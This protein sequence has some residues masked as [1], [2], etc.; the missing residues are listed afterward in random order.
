M[1]SC[2]EPGR[3]NTPWISFS[4]LL[5]CASF[6]A[7]QEGGS[8]KGRRRNADCGAN[9]NE[10]QWQ[11]K[12]GGVGVLRV[13]SKGRNGEKSRIK[14]ES[15]IRLLTWLGN[16][17]QNSFHTFVQQTFPEW[18]NGGKKDTLVCSFKKKM[19]PQSEKNNHLYDGR[20]E[21]GEGS[22]DLWVS[23]VSLDLSF[24]VSCTLVLSFEKVWRNLLGTTNRGQ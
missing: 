3:L 4:P 17:S 11:P 6:S 1:T 9:A 22:P 15:L 23:A 13:E 7:S 12:S 5:L 21:R 16:A 8:E 20:G 2:R 19:F 10:L 18:D 14:G 24:W